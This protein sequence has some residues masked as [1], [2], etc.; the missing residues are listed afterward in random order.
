MAFG[1]K[2]PTIVTGSVA[3]KEEQTAD[4]INMDTQTGNEAL[5][6]T[7]MKNAN[8]YGYD[9][10]G[11]PTVA[12]CQIPL[13]LCYVDERYQ[14]L[15]N[16]G[17]L[18]KLVNNWDIAKCQPIT[19][20][21]HPEENRFAIVDGKGRFLASQILGIKELPAVIMMGSPVEPEERLRFEAVYF[22]GQR[23][24]TENLKGIEKHL[25]RVINKEKPAIILEEAFKKYG[26]GIV[27]GKGNRAKSVLGSYDA[28][29]REAK[30]GKDCID[31]IFSVIV[32]AG[33]NEDSN[34]FSRAIVVGLSRIWEAYEEYRKEIK[35]F[36]SE[37]LRQYDA[38]KFI[39]IAT[40]KYPKRA[41]RDTIVKLYLDDIVSAEFMIKKR[42]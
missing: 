7:I 42:Y 9:N 16:H 28:T 14:G 27:D 23:D 24:E 21:P 26:I 15:R 29:Y 36:L 6:R 10:K 18:M 12:S 35:K 19:L 8:V 20:S 38:D 32:N 40:A 31:F 34:G 17:K 30:K 11:N 3:E 22:I 5:F 1:K 37:E 39:A 41:S 4:I 33:W 2:K 13:E 25:A